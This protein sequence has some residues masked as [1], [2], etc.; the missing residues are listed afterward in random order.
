MSRLFRP[1]LVFFLVLSP[2]L[3]WADEGMW[4]PTL[5]DQAIFERMKALGFALTPEHL[6]STSQ[7]S[8]KDAVVLFGRGCTAEI[9]S[10]QGLILTNHHC[11]F[12]QIQSHSSVENDYLK[13][14]FWAKTKQE[15]LANPGL[16]ASILVRMEDVTK[17]VLDGTLALTDEKE[18]G[19][20]VEAN[21]RKINAE[22]VKGTHYQAQIKPFF[23]GLQYWVLVYETFTDVRLVGT[24]ASSIGKFG[25]D[26]D[27]W[28]W[29]R[30]TGDFCLFRIYAG[31][32]NK[33]APYSPE[34]KPFVPRKY[35]PI[36]TAGIKEGDFTMVLGYP[37]RTMEYLPSYALKMVSETTNPPKIDLRTRRLDIINKAMDQSSLN[38]IRYAAKQSDIANAWKKWKGELLGMKKANAV[39]IKQEKEGR[40][41]QY[42]QAMGETGKPFLKALSQLDSAY[43]DLSKIAVPFELFREAVAANDVF[44]IVGSLKRMAPKKDEKWSDSLRNVR[45]IEFRNL[46]RA[47][48]KDCDPLVERK[49]FSVTLQFYYQHVPARL[50]SPKFLEWVKKYPFEG[51]KF[52]AQFFDKAKILDTGFVFMLADKSFSGK[53]SVLNENPAFQLYSELLDQYNFVHLPTWQF[54]NSRAESAQKIFLTGQMEMEKGKALYPDAN[55]TFRVAFGQVA[56]YQPQDGIKFGWQTTT[57]GIME[58]SGTAD[59]FVLEEGLQKRF[60]VQNQSSQGP[61]PV[62]FIAS[63][64]STGGNSGSPVLN[65]KGELIGINFDRVW[66]GTMSDYFFDSRICRNI[67]CDIRY[68]LWVIETIGQSGHLVKEMEI[69][70]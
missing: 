27:N 29:P 10:N 70:K 48:I 31:K 32:D 59:D 63:N 9:I 46:V 68:V 19:Q 23:G 8:L 55:Q 56:G 16:T 5:I 44:G 14:G 66:E 42:F 35:F 21:M 38:R 34:N 41:M 6:Y 12:G 62:A 18:K 50:H 26:T 33:P 47:T 67:S 36:N 53:P 22:A 11:G 13:N 69:R 7:S 20:K 65:A 2:L 17:Q 61:V 25:G 52:E 30:H 24:P 37:G 54:H 64:H 45:K 4:P 28:V 15:E 3:S 60:K 40:Y 43:Q 1:F 39:G 51:E 49:L 57:A 58:K